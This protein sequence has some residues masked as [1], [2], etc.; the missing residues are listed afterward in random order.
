VNVG[1]EVFCANSG[2]VPKPLHI[3][4]F[5]HFKNNKINFNKYAAFSPCIFYAPTT[6]WLWDLV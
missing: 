2:K 1:Q 6:A 4:V 3:D 5:T